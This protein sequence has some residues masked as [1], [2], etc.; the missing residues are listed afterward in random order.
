MKGHGIIAT[1]QRSL[2]WLET[3]EVECDMVAENA[4]DVAV[5]S[6][7]IFRN[8]IIMPI[9]VPGVGTF[10]NSWSWSRC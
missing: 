3:A 5:A 4:E 1:H 9:E 2:R 6:D 8:T 10:H 7:E